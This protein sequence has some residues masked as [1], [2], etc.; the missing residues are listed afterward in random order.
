MK[1][2][3]NGKDIYPPQSWNELSLKQQLACYAIIMKNTK[4]M[5][6][7]PEHLP[8]RKIVLTKYLLGLSDKFIKDWEEE[9]IEEYGHEDGLL[10]FDN[11]LMELTQVADFFFEKIESNID[12]DNEEVI[13]QY[14]V[15]LGLTKRPFPML[16]RKKKSDRNKR[17]F[18]PADNLENI[19]IYE[20][21]TT[22]TLFE[23]Y[24]KTKNISYVDKLIATM[25]R[26]A[27]P[28]NNKN[29]RS[30]YQGDIRQPLMDHE[31]MIKKRIKNVETLPTA[32][33]QLILFWFASCR[34]KIID[35]YPN[36]FVESKGEKGG[37]QYGWGGVLLELA[38]GL[39]HLKQVGNQSHSNA[40]AYLSYMEDKRKLRELKG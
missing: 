26:P 13:V 9:R 37:N 29:K 33:K 7:A 22:F 21:G 27:K 17:L 36:V 39:V 35:S 25:Y 16:K 23:N 15:K 24:I 8:A 20:L 28:A 19:S 5:L 3:I 4:G 12:G 18:A 2:T 1:V 31:G 40:L 14:Q 6:E 34:Q 11:E 38:G 30:A 32:V 10:I